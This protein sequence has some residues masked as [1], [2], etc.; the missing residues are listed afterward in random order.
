MKPIEIKS[1]CSRICIKIIKD[2][3]NSSAKIK[4]NGELSPPELISLR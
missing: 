4:L 2:L 1:F 3:K